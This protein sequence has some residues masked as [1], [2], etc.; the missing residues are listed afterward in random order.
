MFNFFKSKTSSSEPEIALELNQPPENE[1][2]RL[3]Y[4][5]PGS[6]IFTSNDKISGTIKVTPPN[7]KTV[8]HQGIKVVILGQ[9]R[10]KTDGSLIPFYNCWKSVQKEG[11]ISGETELKFKINV[12]DFQIPSFY[13]TYVDAR[14]TIQAK[15]MVNNT[16]KVVEKPIYLLS[17]DKMPTD[18]Q[19]LKAEVGIQDVLHV[20]FVI[21]NPVF[22]CGSVIIG[23][24]HFLVVKIRIVN[25]CIQI[26]R[27][28]Q[29]NNGII[30]GK[31]ETVISQ[32]EILD[33]M[34]VR[35]DCIPIRFYLTN[36]KAWPF[37]RKTGKNLEVSYNVRFLLIDDNGKHYFKELS[38]YIGRYEITQ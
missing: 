2:Y 26:M 6:I 21:Q 15:I 11:D 24:V 18:L 31:H 16:E 29:F 8:H 22:D 17:I 23:K 28:E 7:G 5:F 12:L 25:M 14:Y 27:T 37:P 3:P 35:G 34:P 13:G 38:N 33:G 36:I 4:F 1:K 30:S 32:Y 19:P 9:N 20:E 10:I